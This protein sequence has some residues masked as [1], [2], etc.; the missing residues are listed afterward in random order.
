MMC[1]FLAFSNLASAKVFHDGALS[2]NEFIDQFNEAKESGVVFTIDKI[3]PHPYVREFSTT[4]VIGSHQFKIV[5]ED[6]P[7]VEEAEG[8]FGKSLL[9]EFV[10]EGLFY[11]RSWDQT[12]TIRVLPTFYKS[13]KQ[14]YEGTWYNEG[15]EDGGWEGV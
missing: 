4:S 1:L 15:T 9:F 8:L 14:Q 5:A 6:F 12:Y 11:M 3:Y 7:L 2:I 10:H 13:P